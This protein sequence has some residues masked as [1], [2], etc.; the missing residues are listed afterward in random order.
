M[1]I[2]ATQPKKDDR[3]LAEMGTKNSCLVAIDINNL[4]FKQ[5]R[6][7]ILKAFENSKRWP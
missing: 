7:I 5:I 1:K 3:K 6:I 2:H 4:K